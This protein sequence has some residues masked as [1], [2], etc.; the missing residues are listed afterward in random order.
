[1]KHLI[2]LTLLSGIILFSSQS[3][4]SAQ[5]TKDL[6][7]F[8]WSAPRSKGAL[9]DNETVRFTIKNIG[10][11]AVSNFTVGFSQDGGNTY[12]EEVVSQTINSNGY[13]TYT[14]SSHTAVMGTDGAT[15][16]IIGKITL[17]GDEDLSNNEHTEQV[18][19]YLIGDVDDEPFVITSFPYLDSKEYI[20]YTDN[21]GE[22]FE[23]INYM[24]QED[25]VYAFNTTETQ[26]Y[27][28][29]KVTADWAGSF[30]P[31]P[32][33][34]LIREK[35][36]TFDKYSPHLDT[37]AAEGYGDWSGSFEDGYC[38]YAQTYYLIVDKWTEYTAS[39]E[40]E[41]N[42][43][44]QHDFKLFNFEALSVEGDIDYENRIVTLTVPINTDVTSLIPTYEL[45]A[46]TEV[47]V[48]GD[49]QTSGST[50]LDFTND[51]T[52]TINQTISP[53]TI[54]TWTIKVVEE[55]TTDIDYDLMESISIAP[56][57]AKDKISIL[58]D[59]VIPVDQISIYNTSGVLVKTEY[60]NNE[61]LTISISDLTDGIYFIRIETEGKQIIKKFIK[62]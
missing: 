40:L 20:M 35:P 52:Y 22:K 49:S 36:S 44:R 32:A 51:V 16:P 62:R 33:V 6:E 3:E 19:N 2:L 58:S 28:D 27:V 23:S 43:Y 41:V 45:P 5:F 24:Q 18:I 13:L 21:Y 26:M 61:D 25:I 50:A 38:Y 1:M 60:S 29:A 30:A 8:S 54:Q 10:T 37:Q 48:D 53:N 47:L 39:Y 57:P 31:R 14:F 59:K 42:L 11:E 56:N 12:K 55:T 7:I 4:L 15:Y 9:T 34:I 46:Y 17:T